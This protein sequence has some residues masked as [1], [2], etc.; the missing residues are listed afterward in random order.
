MKRFEVELADGFKIRV[1]ANDA[2][3]AVRKAEALI[4]AK[5]EKAVNVT[6]CDDVGRKPR[7]DRFGFPRATGSIYD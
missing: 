1:T 5:G 3:H 6:R 2:A 4:C 7:L